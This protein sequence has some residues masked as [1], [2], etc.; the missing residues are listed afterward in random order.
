MQSSCVIRI[1]GGSGWFIETESM[2]SIITYP[3]SKQLL[4]CRYFLVYRQKIFI[5]K[6]RY[7]HYYLK[8]LCAVDTLTFC[9]IKSARNNY[10]YLS[11][12]VKEKLR[13]KVGL[14]C[15][16]LHLSLSCQS[17]KGFYC[18]CQVFVFVVF[19][20]FLFFLI[21]LWILISCIISL[22]NIKMLKR[23]KNKY[24]ICL[25]KIIKIKKPHI[26]IIKC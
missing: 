20:L 21:V 19:L 9:P 15:S 1:S 22:E 14:T 4:L 24:Y 13:N 18:D 7:I 26:F 17:R 6:Y 12:I 10:L 5:Y 8:L 2:F 16:R 11:Q 23:E 25:A 3:V